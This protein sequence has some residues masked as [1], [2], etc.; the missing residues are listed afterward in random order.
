MRKFSLARLARLIALHAPTRSRWS[1]ARRLI[2]RAN[3]ERDARGYAAAR[4]LYEEALQV[5]PDVPR[6]RIHYAHMLKEAGDFA[7]AE[8]LYRSVAAALPDDPD[9]AIQ[10]GHFYK[11]AG[12]PDEAEAAYRHA[13]DLRPGW[14]EAQEELARVRS[15]VPKKG[16]AQDT[17]RLLPELLPNEAPSAPERMREGFFVRRLGATH[18][19]TRGGYRRVLR[20]VEAIH[21]FIVSTAE[22]SELT[23]LADGQTLHRAPLEPTLHLGDGQAKYVFNLWYDFSDL[24]RGPM[25]I[26]LRASRNRG[27]DL[28]H[29]QLI[30]IAPP[31][32]PS[33]WERSDAIVGPLPPGGGTIE[34]RINR[35]PSTTRSAQRGVLA[36]QPQAILVQRADQ[37]GDLICSVPAL[38]RLRELFPDARLVLLATSGNADLARTLPMLD[39]VVVANFPEGADGRRTMRLE[40]QEQLRRTLADYRFDV[41]IDLGETSGSRPL[42]QL[43]GAPFLYGFKDREFPWL[44]A[45]FELNT[46]DPGNRQEAAAVAHKL[47]AMVEGLGAIAGGAP[48]I[49]R[50]DDLDPAMLE[51]FGIAPGERY[52]VLHTGARLAYSRWPGFADLARLLLERTELKVVVMGEE[53]LAGAGDDPRLI[54]LA[55]RM[56]FDEFDA[57]LQYCSLLVGNDSGP[58][59]LAALRGVPVISLHMARLNWSEWGQASGLVMSRRVPCAGCGISSRGE[60]C[61]KQWVCIRHITPEEVFEAASRLL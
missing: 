44:S 54:T 27:S 46:H 35:L 37:L 29:R 43:S 16:E 40:D 21:G 18:A 33:D 14:V 59:H 32:L 39:D 45:G 23:L 10:L 13:V 58:K 42:L 22:L 61:G 50:R 60:E 8:P 31:L 5:A 28:V 48:A 11:V 41:A 3:G 9:I 30:D 56:A 7:A 36:R 4:V 20:G 19:R 17:D 15:A 57:L 53:A 51:R 34:E 6:L 47:L 55:G 26:E 52:A 2:L 1:Q 12:R 49:L 24:A 25:Q 38:Q